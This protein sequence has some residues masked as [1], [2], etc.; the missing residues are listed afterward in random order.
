MKAEKQCHQPHG[1]AV[2]EGR[3][4]KRRSSEW[5][6][7]AKE[8]RTATLTLRTGADPR[9][10]GQIKSVTKAQPRRSPES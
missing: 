10:A 1:T 2:I 5:P 4:N 7:F 6:G 9:N 8:P 3:G